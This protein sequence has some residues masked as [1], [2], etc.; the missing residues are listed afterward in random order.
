MIRVLLAFLMLFAPVVNASGIPVI[1]SASLS[2]MITDNLKRAAQWAKEAEQWA[3][4][5]GLSVDQIKEYKAHADHYK[6]MV[7]GHYSFED[8]VN[9]LALNNVLE[10][11][12]GESCTSLQKILKNFAKSLAW[13][14]RMTVLMST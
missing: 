5:N 11:Q 9:D 8:L 14:K 13:T 2:Q 7:E 6:N 3:I 10:M 1:D 12:G 4:A